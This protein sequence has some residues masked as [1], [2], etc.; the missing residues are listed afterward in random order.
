[1]RTV[2]CSGCRWGGVVSAW[3]VFAQGGVCLGGV[4]PSAYWNT[5]PPVNRMTDAW[6]HFRNYVADDNKRNPMYLNMSS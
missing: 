2:R 1:M 5:H 3:G 4:C 6:K